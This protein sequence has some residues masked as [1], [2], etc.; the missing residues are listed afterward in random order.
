MLGI[1]VGVPRLVPLTQRETTFGRGEVDVVLSTRGVSRAHAKILLHE[2]CATLVDLESRNGT[3]V[4]GDPIDLITLNEGDEIHIGPVASFQFVK[5]IADELE[6]ASRRIARGRLS[7]L[8]PR[9]MEVARA[10][11]RG[12]SNKDVAASLG[13]KPRTVAAHLE[14][15]Y[16]KLDVASRAELAR[17]VTEDELTS[18]Q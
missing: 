2:G 9:E 17:V 16:A 11:A 8:T 1:G 15:A 14:H 10:V 5:R 4:N 12:G 13:I 3:Y 6:Q 7:V 18:N